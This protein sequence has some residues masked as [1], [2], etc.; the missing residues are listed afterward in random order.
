M[1]HHLRY[2]HFD[3]LQPCLRTVTAAVNGQPSAIGLKNALRLAMAYSPQFQTAETNLRIAHKDRLQ[4]RDARPPTVNALNQFI[5]TQGNGTPSGV[6]IA[7]DGVRV[8]NEQAVVRE[9]LLSLVRSGQSRQARAALFTLLYCG[10]L[11]VIERP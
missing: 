10:F 9:N 7:N 4:A 1:P 11:Y 8:Y 2:A 3:S 5:Y 6:F